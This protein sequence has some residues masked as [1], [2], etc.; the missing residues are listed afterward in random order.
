MSNTTRTR[1]TTLH[2][3][4]CSTFEF[5]ITTDG[6]NDGDEPTWKGHETGCKEQTHRIFA[7][8]HDAKLVGFLV[9]AEM[10][11]LEIAQV[12]G[13]IRITSD[14]MHA[15]ARVSEALAE[16]TEAQLAAARRRQ[17]R[18]DAREVKETQAP[19]AVV[20]KIGRWTYD[21]TIDSATGSASYRTAAGVLTAAPVGTYKLV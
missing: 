13:G 4:L 9:R 6:V 5:G 1:K 15:A 17:A 12:V 2:A 7:Q 21:A 20:I 16:K 3:C 19:K 14:A 18:Q 10:A 11:G 8:G